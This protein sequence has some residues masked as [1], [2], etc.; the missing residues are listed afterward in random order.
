MSDKRLITDDPWGTGF[1]DG[2]RMGDSRVS[3]EKQLP[4]EQQGEYRKGLRKGMKD[5]D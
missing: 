3:R 4:E 1:I 2:T 5:D